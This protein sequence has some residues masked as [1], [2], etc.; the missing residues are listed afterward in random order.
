[1]EKCYKYDDIVNGPLIIVNGPMITPAI[2]QHYFKMQY[3]SHKI[4]DLKEQIEHIKTYVSPTTNK[5]VYN[6]DNAFTP[7]FI[8][9]FCK[10]YGISHYAYDINKYVS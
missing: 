8:D 4:K 7:A 9:Y 6:M 10:K 1:M 3:Y 2:K 5:P